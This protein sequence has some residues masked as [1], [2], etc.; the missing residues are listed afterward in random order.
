MFK[1]FYF[2]IGVKLVEPF[3][4]VRHSA[5]KC[6]VFHK[7][8]MSLPKNIKRLNTL[9][10]YFPQKILKFIFSKLGIQPA[11]KAFVFAVGIENRKF[12]F[13]NQ[14]SLDKVYA[15]FYQHS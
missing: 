2:V 7:V 9:A 6:D 3:S 10:F 13:S 11:Y 12:G 8:S 15:G 14:I 1:I 5:E 4:V